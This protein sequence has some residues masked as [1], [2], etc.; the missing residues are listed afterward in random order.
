MNTQKTYLSNLQKKLSEGNFAIT[1]EIGPPK[2]A[3]KEEIKEAAEYLKNFADGINVTDL[4]SSVMRL[5]SLTT[6][7]LLKQWGYEPV[8]QMTARDRNRL[9]LQ[10]D[11][12]SAYVL[13][14]RNVLAITGDYTTIGD[15]PQAEPVFDLDSAQLLWAMKTLEGGKDL[16]GNDLTYKPEFFKG[17]VVNPGA[18]TNASYE[19]QIIKMKKKINLGAQF[20]QTQAIF[21]A[22]VFKR[23]M[24]RMEK[25]KI[26]VPI[27]A[28]IILLKSKGMANYMNKFV[29][30]V[31][32]PE[33]IIEKMEKTDDKIAT[34]IEIA[35]DLINQ[36]KPY[37]SGVHIQA[38][39]WEKHI[40]A[41]IANIK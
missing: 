18:D 20:F 32:V 14:I 9:M 33:H 21:D 38:L 4:Q 24:D 16:V 17:A 37:C 19:L 29:P 26:N 12:L 34:C 23:F 40:P 22:E 36:V 31:F 39:G 28:G 27:L 11:L 8:F 6:C 15:H 7:A 35:S 2:G 5:G 13:G 3:D 30:G 41:V 1:C 10:S 25:E